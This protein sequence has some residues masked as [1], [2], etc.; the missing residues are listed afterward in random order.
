MKPIFL[1][2][3]L[4]SFYFQAFG[5]KV[6]P[7]QLQLDLIGK[8]DAQY[9]AGWIFLGSGT[10]LSLTALVIPRTYDYN[11]GSSNNRVISFL[12]WTGF[13]AIGTS[14]PLFLSAG[15]NA[16]MAAKLSLESQSSIQPIP[17]PGQPRHFPA[18]SLKI[19]L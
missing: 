11:D 2:L 8:S 19:P 18:L 10:A 16:R 17:I 9:K 5:Q 13:L 1:S 15:Q 4:F 7:S 12:G 14:I 3:I 6:E